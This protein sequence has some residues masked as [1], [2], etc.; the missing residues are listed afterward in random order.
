MMQLTVQNVLQI[1]HAELTLDDHL[2]FLVG[3]NEGGKTTLT[4]CLAAL[5][6]SSRTPVTGG[7]ADD[8]KNLVRR[9][10]KR[11]TAA[12]TSTDGTRVIEWKVG[13]T[14]EI[15]GGGQ[16]PTVSPL[17]AGLVRWS[18]LGA[19]ARCAQLAAALQAAPTV[20]DFRQAKPGAIDDGHW[21]RILLRIAKQVE[22]GLWDDAFGIADA[23]AKQGMGA[24]KQITGKS[25]TEKQG[26]EHAPDGLSRDPAK[27]T[28]E[29]LEELRATVKRLNEEQRQ[30][31]AGGM[32][33]GDLAELE[34][35]AAELGVAKERLATHRADFERADEIRQKAQLVLSQ[36][37]EP[38]AQRPTCDCPACGATLDITNPRALVVAAAEEF[39]AEQIAGQRATREAA[40]HEERMAALCYNSHRDVLRGSERYVERCQ[41]AA[42]KLAEAKGAPA[43]DAAEL[44]RISAELDAARA[45]GTALKEW[46]EAGTKHIEIVAWIALRTLCKPEGLR[47]EVMKRRLD[48]LNGQLAKISSALPDFVVA[49]DA[50]MDVTARGY[51]FEF[52]SGAAQWLADVVMQVAVAQLEGAKVVVIDGADILTKTPLTRLLLRQLSADT[53]TRFV[54]SAA[55]DR[56]DFDMAPDLA[57]IGRGATYWIQDGHVAALAATA[58][59]A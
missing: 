22:A 40:L 6:T 28:V 42:T 55:M 43:Q 38:S 9:G 47:R 51:R 53:D 46:L 16:L 25:W 33:A 14:S 39:T 50:D 24:W 19:D 54:V 41:D 23:E 4:R 11:G 27:R 57:G 7:V 36:L 15:T 59:A 12:L 58:E 29:R 32:S 1:G 37:P 21:D 2:T 56:S 34:K 20:Q 17:A 18:Q 30:V 52:L 31:A 49:I 10:E 8:A 13:G 45:E 26:S 44:T 5:L 3:P 35:L 48:E